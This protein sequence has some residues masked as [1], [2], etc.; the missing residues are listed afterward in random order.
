MDRTA[1]A[2]RDGE[3]AALERHQAEIEMEQALIKHKQDSAGDAGS[4]VEQADQGDNPHDDGSDVITA[5][6]VGAYDDA[7][8]NTGPVHNIEL[9]PGE[10]TFEG[11]GRHLL[12]D[13]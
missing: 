8:A 7:P 3:Q 13:Q 4:I 6:G 12:E 9:N 10:R 11:S 5:G 1:E 2:I